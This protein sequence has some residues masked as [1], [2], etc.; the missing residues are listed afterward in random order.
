MIAARGLGRWARGATQAEVALF[1]VTYTLINAV[2][3][4][5][6]VVR[7]SCAGEFYRVFSR[8]PCSL[9]C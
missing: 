9:S 5:N 7:D 1:F 3:M 6:V 2:M 4:M 8:D